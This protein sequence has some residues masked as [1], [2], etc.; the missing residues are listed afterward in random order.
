MTALVTRGYALGGWSPLLAALLTPK[1]E[2][3]TIRAELESAPSIRPDIL[4]AFFIRRGNVEWVAN[5]SYADAGGRNRLDLYRHNSYPTAESNDLVATDLGRW[6]AGTY[7]LK[8][9]V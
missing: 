6:K 8:P 9:G 7:T 2:V 1:L 5:I 3:F 4:R